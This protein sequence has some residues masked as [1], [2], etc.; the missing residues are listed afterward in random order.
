MKKIYNKKKTIKLFSKTN[1]INL[2]ATFKLVLKIKKN[3]TELKNNFQI[4]LKKF[5]QLSSKEIIR[6]NKTVV[7]LLITNKI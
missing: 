6:I 4:T 2:I 5:K 1:V 3:N 7:I